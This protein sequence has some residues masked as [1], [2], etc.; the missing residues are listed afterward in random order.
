[1]SPRSRRL[2]F[3]CLALALVAAGPPAADEPK[4]PAPLARV[5]VQSGPV[6]LTDLLFRHQ[7]PLTR[8][9][10]WAWRLAP[11]VDTRASADRPVGARQTVSAEV[12]A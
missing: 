1:M 9:P 5:R 2:L 12:A 4:A 6:L 11:V 3:V 8:P 7:H 10:E